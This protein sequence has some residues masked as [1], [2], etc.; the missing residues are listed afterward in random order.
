VSAE[1]ISATSF[2]ASKAEINQ[3]IEALR[4]IVIGSRRVPN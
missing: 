2:A 4:S 1:L 3:R